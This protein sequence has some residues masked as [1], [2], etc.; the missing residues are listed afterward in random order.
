MQQQPF[1]LIAAVTEEVLRLGGRPGGWHTLVL[2]TRIRRVGERTNVLVQEVS[3]KLSDVEADHTRQI[4]ALA[5]A[6]AERRGKAAANVSRLTAA[7]KEE[8][9]REAFGVLHERAMQEQWLRASP[10]ARVRIGG[11]DVY[12]TVPARSVTVT[13]T[14]HWRKYS[15]SAGSGSSARM[16]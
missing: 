1:D 13:S 9:S 14:E 2:D 4:E 15:S 10:D 7:L 11:T 12:V 5:R 8:P 16:P 6:V 3:D